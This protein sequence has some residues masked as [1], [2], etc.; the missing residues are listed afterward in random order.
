MN[1]ARLLAA[2]AVI[3]L[4]ACGGEEAEN[5]ETGLGSDTTES[6]WTGTIS[7]AYDQQF[8]GK[9]YKFSSYSDRGQAYI[10]LDPFRKGDMEFNNMTS[11]IMMFQIE[12]LNGSGT[13][14]IEAGNANLTYASSG[15]GDFDCRAESP[16]EIRF[17]RYDDERMTGSYDAEMT[18]DA[19]GEV[20][21]TAE[22]DLIR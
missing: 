22:F 21:I 12:S 19:G 14:P 3:F 7:G 6:S 1:L 20:Q 8:E 17:E 13:A 15:G 10:K 16:G 5:N 18:C 9:G 4:A 2:A 11:L